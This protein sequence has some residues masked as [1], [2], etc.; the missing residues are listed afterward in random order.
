M[1]LLSL[2]GAHLGSQNG[3][4]NGPYYIAIDKYG[5]VY[6]TDSNNHRVQKFDPNG[7]LYRGMGHAG[8]G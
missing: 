2:P 1:E 4:F 3:Q 7:G 8:I 5:A 6:V